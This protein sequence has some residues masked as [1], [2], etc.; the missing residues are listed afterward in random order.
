MAVVTERPA[1]GLCRAFQK[2]AFFQAFMKEMSE[3]DR[4]WKQRQWW[5]R[6]ERTEKRSEDK[7]KQNETEDRERRRAQKRSNSVYV[8]LYTD[9]HRLHFNIYVSEPTSSTVQ[10][11]Q[12]EAWDQMTPGRYH[13]DNNNHTSMANVKIP[14]LFTSKVH[15]LSKAFIPQ[16]LLREKADHL[17]MWYVLQKYS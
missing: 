10:R 16:T 14:S 17:H 7:N 2:Q 1:F 4:W 8:H 3:E 5:G 6:R 15:A 12:S 13:L 11:N 9:I